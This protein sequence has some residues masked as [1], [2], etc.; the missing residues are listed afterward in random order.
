MRSGMAPLRAALLLLAA[1][2]GACSRP[3]APAGDARPSAA[4]ADHVVIVSVDGLRP[5]ALADRAA[6]PA[7]ARLLDGAA[8]LDAR[9]DPDWSLT[10]PN[11]VGM[12]TGRYTEGDEGH[13]WRLND[14]PPP[15]LLLRSGQASAFHA[16]ANAGLAT[17]MVAGKEK[18][19][20]F[21]RSW[22]GGDGGDPQG[23]IHYY[24]WPGTASGVASGWL[25]FWSAHPRASLMLAHFAEPD[26]AGHEHGWDLQPG[27]A[28]LA[29]VA[30]V[31]AALGRVLAWLDEHPERRART[32]II[33]TADHGGGVPF[34]HHRS[35][36][37]E[38]VN[39]RIPFL[40]WR[41]DGGAR[42]D[43]YA[44]NG[45]TRRAPGDDDPERGDAGL[46]PLR[47]LD[48]ADAALALLGLPLLHGA[49]PLHLTPTDGP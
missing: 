39:V 14:L 42:G 9:C 24:S 16:A 40:V 10:L 37:R 1:L 19:V 31:D 13:G 15:G 4:A 26:G 3:T 6:L 11:H 28:Y 33:L 23:I 7:F 2:T 35:E 44:L 49:A 17:A 48:A 30:E 45:R 38:L 29:A 8:T 43:L 34:K 32:A 21:P 18:F 27:S 22:N 36:P 12:L 46:P 41:G 5:D 47:N 20:L 25:E